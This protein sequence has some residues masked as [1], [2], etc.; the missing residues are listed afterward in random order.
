MSDQVIV[1]V[2]VPNQE[3]RPEIEAIPKYVQENPVREHLGHGRF[4]FL[5]L[6]F[7]FLFLKLND[8]K[9]NEYIVLLQF[10]RNSVGRFPSIA[11]LQSIVTLFVTC[12]IPFAYAIAFGCR[13][14]VGGTTRKSII[15]GRQC[16]GRTRF[17]FSPFKF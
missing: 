9:L 3:I 4:S 5:I 1:V 16:C 13:N 11:D 15:G 17:E 8:F 7:F 14:I 10:R 12:H 2:V 6:F